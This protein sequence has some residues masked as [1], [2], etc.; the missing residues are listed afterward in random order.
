MKNIKKAVRLLFTAFG[1]FSVV[2]IIAFLSPRLNS[3]F[4]AIII[5]V[6]VALFITLISEFLLTKST[7]FRWTRKIFS[8]F[9]KY[10][11]RWIEVLQDKPDY[12]YAICEIIYTGNGEY[13]FKGTNY[14]RD[15][16]LAQRNFGCDKFYLNK[17]GFGYVDVLHFGTTKGYGTY[18]FSNLKPG[19][20]T[21]ATGFFVDIISHCSCDLSGCNGDCSCKCTLCRVEMYQID[22]RF[23]KLTNINTKLSERKL[24]EKF[25]EWKANNP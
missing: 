10:E 7:E 18:S 8:P 22:K 5:A 20:P 11:G 14:P 16:S 6:V 17:N 19:D 24:I 12:P 25:V 3:Y 15:S 9:A 4:L 2:Q 21:K 1:S 13:D 23:R